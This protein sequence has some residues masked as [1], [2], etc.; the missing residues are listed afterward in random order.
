VLTGDKVETAV[1]IAKACRL[2]DSSMT[3]RWV[4]RSPHAVAAFE[5]LQ[6][7]EE[8]HEAVRKVKAAEEAAGGPAWGGSRMVLDGQ[9]VGHILEDPSG[10][11]RRALYQLRVASR[12]CVCCR[13]SP[14][15]KKERVQLV[16]R[17]DPRVV[18][19]AIG[20]GA[21]DVPMI[22]GAHIGVGIRGKEGASA[23]QA[24][25]VAVSQFRFLRF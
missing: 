9:S 17:E 24:A 5:A 16:R 4:V 19:L 3:L 23:V 25:H 12:A 7:A 20:D 6:A 2:F 15:Q 14:A 1:E 22:Q 21:N 11:A 8:K 13:L 10:D 18:T